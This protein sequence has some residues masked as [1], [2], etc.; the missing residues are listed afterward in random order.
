[1]S[2]LVYLLI[3]IY[4]TWNLCVCVF[5]VNLRP[6]GGQYIHYVAPTTIQVAHL[7]SRG[8]QPLHLG[9]WL[10]WHSKY[11]NRVCAQKK[12]FTIWSC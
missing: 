2:D 7:C 12:A 5:Q 10:D 3:I 6:P 8:F 4:N 9:L 1:M 11:F